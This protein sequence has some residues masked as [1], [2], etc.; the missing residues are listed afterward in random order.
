VKTN[1]PFL[2]NLILHPSFISGEATTTFIDSTPELFQ[3]GTEGTGDEA[4][5]LSWGCDR[6][7]PAGGKGEGGPEEG[8]SWSGV[9]PLPKGKA[10]RRGRG[11]SCWSWAR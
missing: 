1:I 10:P 6:Q 5:Q 3:F 4:A 2:E 8:T 9:A 7:R 11:T